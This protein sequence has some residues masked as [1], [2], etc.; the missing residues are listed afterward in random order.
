MRMARPT[1]DANIDHD[2]SKHLGK[3]RLQ[4]VTG[5]RATETSASEARI[6]LAQGFV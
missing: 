3:V 4:L 2:M 5:H 1:G 6:V